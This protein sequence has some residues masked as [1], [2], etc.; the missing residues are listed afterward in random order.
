MAVRIDGGLWRVGAGG[1]ARAQSGTLGADGKYHADGSGVVM[2]PD[3]NVSGPVRRFDGGPTTL[4]TASTP[5]EWLRRDSTLFLGVL[6]A[7]LAAGAVELSSNPFPPALAR[8]TAEGRALKEK[9]GL[10]LELGK[11][12]A[13]ARSTLNIAGSTPKATRFGLFADGSSLV[14]RVREPGVPSRWYRVPLGQTLQE[15]YH[16][17]RAVPRGAPLNPPSP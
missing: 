7:K 9:Y 17:S 11:L 13:N 5:G 8:D 6:E 10:E 3:G 12:S 14:V 16:H 1:L 4:F 2:T 15:T